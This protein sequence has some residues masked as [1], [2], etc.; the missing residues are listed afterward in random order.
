MKNKIAIFV[1]GGVVQA[2]R[3][4]ISVDLDVE[5]VDEDN[6]P[7]TAENRWQELQMELEFENF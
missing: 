3:S 7:D 4:N 5:L 6:E 2:I 1:S